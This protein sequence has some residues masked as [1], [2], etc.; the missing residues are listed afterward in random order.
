MIW[1]IIGNLVG[2]WL[3]AKLAIEAIDTRRASRRAT[4][5]VGALT[6]PIM[7]GLL[8]VGMILMLLDKLSN[9][10]D[11]HKRRRRDVNV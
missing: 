2:M 6:W 11:D 9:W 7:V 10:W 3:G 5:L 8:V 1:L 4:A